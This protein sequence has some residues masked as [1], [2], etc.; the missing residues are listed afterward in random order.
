MNRENLCF[1]HGLSIEEIDK[2]IHLILDEVPADKL[3][4]KQRDV[5]FDLLKNGD[6]E[7]DDEKRYLENLQFRLLNS[8]VGSLACD[9][10]FAKEICKG[11][12]KP[13]AKI[14]DCTQKLIFL[15]QAVRLSELRAMETT[16]DDMQKYLKK[17]TALKVY[18]DRLGKD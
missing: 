8:L 3:T 10:C 13:E 1:K 18:R 9:Q 12:G 11:K 2:A 5:I 7:M 6:V 16:K 4:P 14:V 17:N 15:M